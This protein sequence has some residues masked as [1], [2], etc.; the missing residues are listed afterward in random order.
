MWEAECQGL[1][2]SQKYTDYR[3]CA[4]N[5]ME[6]AA[7]LVEAKDAWCTDSDGGVDF[8]KKGVVKTDLN[9]N[10]IEDYVYTWGTTAYVIEGACSDSKQYL[11]Y[12]K[13]CSEFGSK[14]VADAAA[15][16]CVLKNNPPVIGATLGDQVVNEEQ[17]LK[18]EVIA[19][20]PDG[21]NVT[22]SYKNLPEGAFV[23][24]GVFHWTPAYGKS[25]SY[26]III[27]VSDG[28]LTVQKVFKITVVKV[29][30]DS[31]KGTWAPTSDINVPSARFGHTAIWTGEEMI[32][33]GGH[34]SQGKSYDGDNTGYRF[35]PKTGTWKKISDPPMEFSG[36]YGHSA[37]W[38][39]K[40]MLI[41]GGQSWNVG[42]YTTL[43]SGALYN[44]ATDSWKIISK[45]NAP[46]PRE[47][48]LSVWTGSKFILWGGDSKFG[49]AENNYAYFYD[50]FAYEPIT[51]QWNK[52][53]DNSILDNTSTDGSAVWTGKEMIIWNSK[54]NGSAYAGS[55]YNPMTN[56]WLP[57]SDPGTLY[58]GKYNHVAVWTGEEM[59]IWGG[60]NLK[61]GDWQDSVGARYNPTTDT[62]KIIPVS[63]APIGRVDPAVVWTGE[64]MIVWGGWGG[65][66]LDDKFY[67]YPNSLNSG[68][69]FNPVTNKWISTSM[70][71]VPFA[72]QVISGIWTGEEMIVWGGVGGGIQSDILNDGGIY[73]P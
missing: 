27:E 58:L 31:Q 56:T 20:D 33:W 45:V 53:L 55:R 7:S 47:N 32:V 60:Q 30:C 12:Y 29:K 49:S 65:T 63:C 57:I 68:G 34:A 28:Q 64:E 1:L 51:D 73:K 3:T 5:V 17:E 42:I 50:G 8:M 40:E 67:P 70:T 54:K 10:G 36:R 48:A 59:I 9:P 2:I 66:P 24:N 14:Y 38:T 71:N 18:F 15:G 19:S 16:A 72:R 23:K 4:L 13:N 41:F 43:N 25:G 11:M 21:D 52:I 35:N 26:E 39:G 62:W 6:K 61:T 69:R 46:S 37:V 44:P 22:I